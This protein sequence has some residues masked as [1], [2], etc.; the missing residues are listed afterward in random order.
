MPRIP[1]LRRVFRLD[2]L[3]PRVER[4]VDDE[5]AFHLAET[6]TRLEARGLAPAVARAEAER[7]FGDLH[8]YRRELRA[9]DRGRAAA[10]RRADLREATV[11]D[12]RHALRGLRRNP[13]FTL[14]V[15]L[16]LALGIGANAT[17]FGLVD[18]LILRDPPHVV[19]PGELRSVMLRYVFRGE[20]GINDVQSYPTLRDLRAGV[21]ALSHL[22]GYGGAQPSLGRGVEAQPVRATIVTGD[23]FPLLGT[24]AELGRLLQPADDERGSA[25][26][27]VISHGFWQRHF[28]GD[29]DV[30]GRTLQLDQVTYTVVGVAPPGFVGLEQRRTPE[31]WLPFVPRAVAAGD[32]TALQEYGWQSLYVVGRL[33]PGAS[34]AQAEAQSTVVFRSPRN[35]NADTTARALVRSVLPRAVLSAA[36]D[37]SLPGD[38]RANARVAVLLAGV[39]L[40]V[41]LIACANVA[42]LLLARALQRRREIAVR[43]ALGVSRRRLALQLVTESLLLAAAGGLAALL[44]VHWGGLLVRHLLLGDVAWEGSPVDGRVLAFTAVATVLTGLLTG[45]VPALQAS[46]PSLTSALRTG[47]RAGGGGGRHSRLRAALLVTQTVLSVVLLAGTGLFVRSLVRVGNERLGLDVDQV[48]VGTMRLRGLGYA[49]P[50]VEA[51]YREMAERVGAVPGVRGVALAT[52]LPF[53]S[54]SSI[55]FR[56]P[57]RDSLP[58]VADGGPYINAVTPGYLR[59]VGTRLLRGRDFTDADRAGT[60]PVAIVNQAMAELYWPGESAIGQCIIVGDTEAPCTT[61]VGVMENARRQGIVEGTSLQYLVPLEQAPRFLR[62]R[63]L[64]ARVDQGA[65]LARV[66]AAVARAMQGVA[67]DLPYADVFP[68]SDLLQGELR[69]WR[70]GA[71]LFGAFGALALLLAAVGLYGVV[72]YSVSQR[73]QELGVRMALGAQAKDVRLLVLRQG[74]ALAAAGAIVG[75]ALALLL[76]PRVG[77]L[78]FE[79]SP[80]DPVVFGGVVTTMLVVAVAACLAPAWRAS[81]VDP[82][83]TMRAE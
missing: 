25:P 20:P 9:I 38:G 76:A 60:A 43:L 47:L 18:R 41:L 34:D 71:A 53:Y 4:D 69:P 59:T 35:P 83:I 63:Q 8:R 5:L 56:L 3:S 72:A 66:S 31:V 50:R 12:L 39:S 61:V 65:D 42:N 19:A 37:E 32:T 58:R 26:V 64:V 24:R 29:P 36:E 73:T 78:L 13:G 7:R 46:R 68:M 2:V 16:T 55:T 52:A 54:T 57:G 30:V 49:P 79:T 23:Y 48:L 14:A 45:L 74:V 70:M 33:R 28:G 81:R 77:D 67:A 10:H 1:H 11:H 22:A 82:A 44:V 6:V 21:P 51:M 62:G 80:R 75:G 40:L 15:V 27:A 17:M